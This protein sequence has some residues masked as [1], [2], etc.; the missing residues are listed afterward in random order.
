MRIGIAGVSSTGKSTLS[1]ILAEHKSVA[2]ISDVEVHE[3]AW[4]KLTE[5]NLHP[6][7]RFFPHLTPAE[8]INFERAVGLSFLEHVEEKKSFVSD[9]TPLDFINYFHL[10]CAKHSDDLIPSDELSKM[11]N[12]MWHT[13][14]TYDIIYYLPFGI[15]PVEDDS[16]RFTNQH[17]LRA[18][19]YSL[20]GVIMEARTRGI[21]IHP[22]YET[23]PETRLESIIQYEQNNPHVYGA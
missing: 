18:W 9:E 11:V 14:F 2:H 12:S 15:I 13:M 21:H 16:R 22:I 8:H 1:R 3:R 4:D 19:D 7:T 6:A 23:T 17:L 20:L 5:W 10:V